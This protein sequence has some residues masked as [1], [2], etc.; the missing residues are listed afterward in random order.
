[1]ERSEK[2]HGYGGEGGAGGEVC[3]RGGGGGLEAGHCEVARSLTLGTARPPGAHSPTSGCEQCHR[4][5]AAARPLSG[6][7]LARELWEATYLANICEMSANVFLLGVHLR[8]CVE[9]TDGDVYKERGGKGEVNTLKKLEYLN[10]CFLIV[11]W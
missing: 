8:T 7:D 6:S 3:V 4:A 10:I 2:D 5:A 11:I 1:M 9:H